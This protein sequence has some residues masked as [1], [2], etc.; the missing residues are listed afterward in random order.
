ME[1][2]GVAVARF[3]VRPSGVKLVDPADQAETG[4]TT[5]LLA[6]GITAIAAAFVGAVV[7]RPLHWLRAVRMTVRLG[8]RSER[9]ILRHF[10]YLAEACLLLRRL[11]R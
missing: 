10:I 5:V 4:R 9:G 6:A 8:R 1:A 11:Q 3:S 2:G 7:T